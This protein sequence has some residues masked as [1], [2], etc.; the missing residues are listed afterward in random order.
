MATQRIRILIGRM[1]TK[2][3]LRRKIHSASRVRNFI[4]HR[5][6]GRLVRTRCVHTLRFLK[7]FRPVR[8]RVVRPQSCFPIVYKEQEILSPL[9]VNIFPT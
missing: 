9:A 8:M 4:A 6:N 7:L 2:V 3:S 1:S 5:N